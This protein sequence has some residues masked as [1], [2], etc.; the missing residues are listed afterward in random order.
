MK[1]LAKFFVVIG[2]S[3]FY[4]VSAFAGAAFADAPIPEC[5]AA[6]NSVNAASQIPQL[7]T[8]IVNDCSIMYV[9]GWK[10]GGS[11]TANPS[12]CAPAWNAIAA[13]GKLADAKFLVSTNCP[14]L[15]K[16]GLVKQ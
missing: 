13:A 10:T 1:K 2:L 14:I 7:K 4:A 9:Q 16:Q 12:V 5:V 3:V 6:W 15:A 11:G 8:L